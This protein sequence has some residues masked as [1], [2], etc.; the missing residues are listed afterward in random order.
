MNS[1]AELNKTIKSL[2]YEVM[3]L[4]D[5]N[6]EQQEYIEDLCARRSAATLSLDAL[7]RCTAEVIGTPEKIKVEGLLSLLENIYHELNWRDE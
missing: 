5:A 1:I 4:E 7:I 2:Q 3:T 6:E